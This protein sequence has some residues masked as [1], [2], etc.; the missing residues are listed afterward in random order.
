[1][2]TAPEI[3]EVVFVR[4]LGEIVS[5]LVPADP[6]PAGTSRAGGGWG[7]QEILGFGTTM[8]KGEVWIVRWEG[9]R[10]AWEKGDVE[11]L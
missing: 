5:I 2:I 10:E 8:R 7:R 6:P 11:I 4:C 1:M 3:K 9:V